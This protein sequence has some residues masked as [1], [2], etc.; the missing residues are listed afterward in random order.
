[1]FPPHYRFGPHVA[2]ALGAPDWGVDW[3]GVEEEILMAINALI[4]DEM[5]RRHR[6]TIDNRAKAK[7]PRTSKYAWMQE[8]AA[9]MAEDRPNTSDNQ[10]AV[11]VLDA[12][13]TETENADDLPSERTIRGWIKKLR[14]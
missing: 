8:L 12:I 7:K 3:Q 6:V 11:L 4:V 9:Q 5:R 1:M 14:A 2:L 13:Q 10:L